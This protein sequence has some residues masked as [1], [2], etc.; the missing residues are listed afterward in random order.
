MREPL[1]E[2]PQMSLARLLCLFSGWLV[3]LVAFLG[4]GTIPVCAQPETRAEEIDLARRD[5][6]ARLWPERQNQMVELLNKWVERGLLD[7]AGTGKGSNGP[8][9]VFGGMR[10]GHG[11][12]VGVGYRRSD[13]WREQL[14]FRFAGRGTIQKAYMFDLGLDF[15]KLQGR[16][17]FLEFR[18]KWENSPQMDYFGPGP[19][20]RE[21]DRTSYRL[22]DVAVDLRGG[23]KIAGPL[24][25][26]GTFGF[27]AVNTG[28]GRRSGVPSTDE[29]FDSTT[30]PGLDAQTRF[31]RGGA[32]LQFDWRDHPLG[33]RTGGNYLIRFTQYFD[34]KLNA[35][36]FGQL[37]LVAEQYFPYFNKARVIALR[38]AA[39][40]TFT[41]GSNTVPFYLQPTLGGNKTLRGF[42]IGR[43]TDEST[44]MATVEHRWHVFS[45][46]DAA[47]FFDLGKVA[48][49]IG[50]LNFDEL[51]Y[52]GGLGLR[53]KV[54]DAV[55]LR[56]DQ[57]VSREGY[58]VMLTFSN[59]F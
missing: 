49:K 18:T 43:F 24:K 14:D 40:M 26:G 48:P 39:V 53:F 58:R 34:R 8:Q 47:L 52:G 30:T 22:E 17:S 3:V 32:F 1:L 9:I 19:S 33:P 2:K 23:T 20:S 27:L 38:L 28:P 29:I 46:L 36:D 44:I 16:R 12:S 56:I 45:A 4:W 37:D 21:E 57:A 59:V 35:H 7:E 42:P 51:E 25:G 11:L 6:K 41:R 54:R 50:L 31:L 5:K 10:S 55:V 15:P 13:W